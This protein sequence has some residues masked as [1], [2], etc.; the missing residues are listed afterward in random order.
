[1]S[2][3]RTILESL[4]KR[5]LIELASVFE[6]GPGLSKLGKDELVDEFARLRRTKLDEL[7]PELSRDELK[8]A[9]EMMGLDSAG[10]E[11]QVIIDRI[12]GSGD[13]AD[14][15]AVEDPT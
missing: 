8:L 14:H 7:L 5:R 1:M 15:Q 4:T 2:A 3:K 12:L 10:R 9:C 13:D 6:V 11:K